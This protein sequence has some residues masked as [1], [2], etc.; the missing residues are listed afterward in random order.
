MHPTS[1]PWREQFVLSRDFRALGR[2]SELVSR[3]RCGEL[4]PI[5]AGVYRFATAV[6]PDETRVADDAFLA[7][8]RAT[9]LLS[10]APLQFRNHAAAAVWDLP[11]VGRWPERVAIMAAPAPGGRSNATLARSYLGHPAAAVMRDGLLVTTLARTVADVARVAPF[12]TATAMTDAALH[13]HR[14]T[15]GHPL[16]QRLDGEVAQHEFAT[17]GRVVGAARARCVLEFADAASESA[18]ESF[19]RVGIRMLSLPAPQLQV[20]FADARGPIGVVDFFWRQFGVIGEFDGRGKYLREEFTLGRPIAD[21]VMAEKAREN[22]LRAL[23]FVV[24]RWDWST[25]MSLPLL[26]ACLAQGGVH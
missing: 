20:P 16:R 19:S 22:R 14:E 13:G 26:R 10:A 2:H 3:V 5:I 21:I 24:V 17:L 23:G 12:G 1:A 25:A 18:G 9:Q 6:T 7:K 15:A 8:I 11:M 4:L